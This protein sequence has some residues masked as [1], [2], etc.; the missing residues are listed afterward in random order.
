MAKRKSSLGAVTKKDFMA[1]A[2]VLCETG[3]NKRT[4]EGLSRYF[5][6]RNPRFNP[7]RFKAATRACRR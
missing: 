7:S 3:A 6:S 1:I 2:D 5:R 4:V